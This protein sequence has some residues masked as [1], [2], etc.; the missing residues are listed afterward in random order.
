MIQLG[1]VVYYTCT[2][3]VIFSRMGSESIAASWAIDSEAMRAKGIIVLVKSNQLVKNI[4]TKTTLASKTRFSRRCFDFQSRCFSLLV[5]YNT[6]PTSSST[7]QNAALI[8][9]CQLDFTKRGYPVPKIF[10]P[11]LEL[12]ELPKNYCVCPYTRRIFNA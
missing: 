2:Y 8:I 11:L 4:E 6:Q 9:V 1:A 5:G 7:N 10:T 12:L 3:T